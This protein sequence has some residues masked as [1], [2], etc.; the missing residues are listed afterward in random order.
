M[1]VTE[2]IS[3]GPMALHLMAGITTFM[4]KP[5]EENQKNF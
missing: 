2:R 4:K 1:A 3:S 5:P